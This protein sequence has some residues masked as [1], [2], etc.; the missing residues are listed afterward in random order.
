MMTNKSLC[1]AS[2]KVLQ[3]FNPGWTQKLI[4]LIPRHMYNSWQT[5]HFTGKPETKKLMFDFK[6]SFVKI[7][8][9]FLL[10]TPLNI[11]KKHSWFRREVR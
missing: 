4:D 9:M 6:C 11:S 2:T 10:L 3:I 1:W 8:F 7:R 5:L